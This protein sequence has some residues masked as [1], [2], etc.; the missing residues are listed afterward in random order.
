LS[1]FA[2]ATSHR[3]RAKDTSAAERFRFAQQTR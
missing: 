2:I 1:D 3:F